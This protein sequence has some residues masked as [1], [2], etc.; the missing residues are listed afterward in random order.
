MINGSLSATYNRLKK[1]ELNRPKIEHIL[2][3]IKKN[4]FIYSL[5]EYVAENRQLKLFH[6]VSSS[7]KQSSYFSP[8]PL[9]LNQS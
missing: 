6:D 2:P 3:D 4:G 5:L 8:L 1:K 9:K 7:I